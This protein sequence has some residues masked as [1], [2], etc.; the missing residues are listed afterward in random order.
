MEPQTPHGST[1]IKLEFKDINYHVTVQASK[2]ERNRGAP[3]TNELHILKNCTGYCPPGK[4]TWIMG[5]SGAGKTSLLNLLSDRVT[6]KKGFNR[7]TG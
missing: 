5:A 2:Q 3:K 4:V 6:L 7:L 1:A